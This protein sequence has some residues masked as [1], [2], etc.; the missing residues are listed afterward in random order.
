MKNSR[1]QGFTLIEL[2]VVISIISLLSSIVL[3]GLKDARDKARIASGKQFEQ[4]LRGV[5]NDDILSEWEFSNDTPGFIVDSNGTIPPKKIEINPGPSCTGHLYTYTQGLTGQTIEFPTPY[6]S[7]TSYVELSYLGNG[8]PFFP[9]YKDSNKTYTISF[10]VKS[11][12]GVVFGERNSG[13]AVESLGTNF[14]IKSNGEKLQITIRDSGNVLLDQNSNK[15]VF[16]SAWHY[17]VWSDK[18]GTAT[19]YVDGQ[20]DEN[21]FN[22]TRPTNMTGGVNNSAIGSSAPNGWPSSGGQEF[23]G[24]IDQFR[25]YNKTP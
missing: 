12:G 4:S 15:T 18:N 14:K 24:Q 11:S 20:P 10:W 17:I 1:G 13:D 7:C 21:N 23:T 22:Y 25:I 9:I 3:A 5:M 19:L 2:L 8:S 6:F 16:N